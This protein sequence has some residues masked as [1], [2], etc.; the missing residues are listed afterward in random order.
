MI[1]SVTA[2]RDAW[3][4][5][6]SGGAS[7]WLPPQPLAFPRREG[8]ERGRRRGARA[9][10]KLRGKRHKQV[11]GRDRRGREGV[12]EQRRNREGEGRGR[13]LE[14]RSEREWGSEGEVRGLGERQSHRGQQGQEGNP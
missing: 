6:S 10:L 14:R 3:A 9:P 4:R 7:H 8:E 13:R 1:S 5:L 2:P 12:P 11:T